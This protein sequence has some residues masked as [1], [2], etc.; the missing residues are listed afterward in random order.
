M[1][2][3]YRI[4]DVLLELEGEEK[5]IGEL[6]NG[7]EIEEAVG[8]DRV[9]IV[10]E[11]GEVK[12][13][14]EEHLLKTDELTIYETDKEYLMRYHRSD[15]VNGCIVEKKE[16]SATIFVKK[17]KGNVDD[18]SY[19]I[20]NVFFYYIQKRGKT[21][22]HSASVL[23]RGRAWLFSAPSGTGKSSHVDFWKACDY[24]VEDINGDMVICY[25]DADGQAVV[26]GTPWCGTSG[27]CRNMICSMGGIIFLK[28]GNANTVRELNIFE[29]I[30]QLTARSLTPNWNRECVERNVTIAEELAAKIHMGEMRCT[31]E[32]EAAGVS[33]LFIDQCIDNMEE[34]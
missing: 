32:K 8:A 4:A 13:S 30:L 1:K 22:I 16:E 25:T 26:A 3:Y 34:K 33:R 15:A 6:M 17:T 28:R 5:L 10:I 29:G 31:Y 18:I 11:P 2:K 9:R 12:F 21:V 20:R 19:A 24:P 23:Y 7:F 27:I 14:L